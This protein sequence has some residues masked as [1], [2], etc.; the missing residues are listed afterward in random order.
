MGR[1]RRAGTRAA[2]TEGRVPGARGFAGEV[3][4]A[5]LSVPHSLRYGQ[6]KV[7]ISDAYDHYKILGGRLSLEGFKQRLGEEVAGSRL[8]L[9][10]ADLA[11]PSSKQQRSGTYHPATSRLADPDYHFI[12]LRP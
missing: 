3:L 7:W 6:D 11:R 5:A 10:R 4:E 9:T 2:R 8:S 1:G 12:R